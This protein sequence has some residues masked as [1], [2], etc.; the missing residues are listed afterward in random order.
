MKG[1]QPAS[2]LHDTRE[3]KSAGLLVVLPPL[4]QIGVAHLLL[5]LVKG[6]VVEVV[7][8]NTQV[9]TGLSRR[10]TVHNARMH[11]RDRRRFR[12]LLLLLCLLLLLRVIHVVFGV[13]V[14]RVQGREGL[15]GGRVLSQQHL[16]V[17]V[18]RHRRYLG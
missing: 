4:K 2:F 13:K 14:L 3:L 10:R 17:L 9:Q 6:L 15:F 16:V 11:V 8:L 12:D 18:R 7:E 1:L 5:E